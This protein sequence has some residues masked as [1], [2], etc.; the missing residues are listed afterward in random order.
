M[1]KVTWASLPDSYQHG[2][3]LLEG[4]K[5]GGGGVKVKTWKEFQSPSSLHLHAKALLFQAT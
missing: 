2:P 5:G 3:Y 4:N 1:T